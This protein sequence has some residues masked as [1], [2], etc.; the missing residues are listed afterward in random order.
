VKKEDLGDFKYCCQTMEDHVLDD[1][2]LCNPHSGEHYMYVDG[3]VHGLLWKTS[4]LFIQHCPFCG[5]NLE[6][7]K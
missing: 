3:K 2:I 1:K 4:T 5:K 7:L 6:E